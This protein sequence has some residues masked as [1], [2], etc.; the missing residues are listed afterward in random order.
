MK[1]IILISVIIGALGTLGYF[2]YSIVTDRY[3]PESEKTEEKKVETSNRTQVPEIPS[4]NSGMETAQPSAEEQASHESKNMQ[5]SQDKDD[6]DES[7]DMMEKSARTKKTVQLEITKEHCD[8]QCEFFT[9]DPTNFKYCSEV[10]GISP[11]ENI[12]DCKDK[13]DLERDY[14]QKDL[15]ITKMNVSLCD[16]ITDANIRKTC[17]KRINED[18][19]EKMNPGNDA[20]TE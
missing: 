16:P 8:S 15:A 18:L 20:T 17:Q 9:H 14:C 12:S 10:F 11:I 13:K 19:L 1:K 2:T 3:F 5:S 4:Q 7:D 6:Q